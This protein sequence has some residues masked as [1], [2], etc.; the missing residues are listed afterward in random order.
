MTQSHQ[1]TEAEIRRHHRLARKAPILDWR[2]L[3]AEHGH[4]DALA[5]FVGLSMHDG[6][7][8]HALERQRMA[9]RRRRFD[10]AGISNDRIAAWL[11]AHTIA[12]ASRMAEISRRGPLQTS[13]GVIAA[14]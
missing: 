14:G 1:P 5:C 6:A 10:V 12:F 7:T 2:A 4:E 9:D 11:D 3:G 13:G 8:V